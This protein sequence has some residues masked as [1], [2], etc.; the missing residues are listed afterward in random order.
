MTGAIQGS[1]R[2]TLPHS[3]PHPSPTLTTTH[4]HHVKKGGVGGIWSL[5]AVFDPWHQNA[6]GPK[7]GPQKRTFLL[8][9]KGRGGGMP[10]KGKMREALVF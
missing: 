8:I 4:L 3:L 5:F 1:S 6:K 10:H 9:A 2:V 7:E